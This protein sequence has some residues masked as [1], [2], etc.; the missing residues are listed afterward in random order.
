MADF[1]ETPIFR[2]I[3]DIPDMPF[4]INPNDGFIFLGSCFAQHIGGKFVDYGLPAMVNPMGVLYNPFSIDSILSHAENP[5]IEPFVFE[6]KEKFF[7]WLAG[8]HICADSFEHCL[9]LVQNLLFQIRQQIQRSKFAF[10]TLGTNVVYR[11][12]ALD[13]IVSNC[14]RM[15]QKTFSEE[16]MSLENCIKTL[17]H[18]IKVLREIN[19]GIQL[20]FTVSPY[21]YAKYGFHG[22]QLAKA[23]LLLAVQ[24][25]CESFHDTCTYFPS[26]EI[27]LDELRDYR[28]YN[29]DMLHPSQ[30]SIDYIWRRLVQSTFSFNAQEYLN[31]FE[32]IRKGLLHRPLLSDNNE[33]TV[34]KAA[35]KTKAE[36]IRCKYGIA[37]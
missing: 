23:T 35:L 34:R 28:F 26:Y 4:R 8:T 9:E 15:P 18:S 20:I 24:S 3:V 19:D 29:E 6:S 36:M 21:R 5:Q 13:A 22:S 2:T 33:E 1:R 32:P 11:H 10:I 17:T 31:E 30:E 14:H 16:H 25:V 7:C 27:I 37:T 12:K